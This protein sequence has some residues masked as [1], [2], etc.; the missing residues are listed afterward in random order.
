MML[1]I[2]LILSSNYGV[3]SGSWDDL[4]RH[5]TFEQSEY[6]QTQSVN[7]TNRAIRAVT[8]ATRFEENGVY[9]PQRLVNI[10]EY[11]ETMVDK[12]LKFSE[13]GAQ[14][15]KEMMEVCVDSYC[16][17]VEAFFKHDKEKAVLAIQKEIRADEL[18]VK[19]RTKHI[20]RLANQECNTEAG[21]IFLDTVICLERISDHARNIAEEVI[22]KKEI[23]E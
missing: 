15:L 21:I 23:E 22:G 19:L 16:Y 2:V 5:R 4:L 20:K 11:A 13:I 17:A 1:I 6:F 12:K 7:Q 9:D 8:R 3:N 14:E 10:S 18:E